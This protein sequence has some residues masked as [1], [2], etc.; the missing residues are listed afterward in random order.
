LSD[1][2][3]S[4]KKVTSTNTV[5]LVLSEDADKTPNKSETVDGTITTSS[6]EV[7]SETVEVAAGESVTIYNLNETGSARRLILLGVTVSELQ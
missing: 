1:T 7:Y 5:Y 3:F 2:N 6:L 4:S